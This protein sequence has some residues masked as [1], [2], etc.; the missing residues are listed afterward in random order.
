MYTA[1]SHLGPDIVKPWTILS[2]EAGVVRNQYNGRIYRQI[3][4]RRQMG[5]I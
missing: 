4:G 1:E 5:A 3:D 2:G